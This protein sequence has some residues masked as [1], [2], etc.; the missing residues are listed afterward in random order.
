M[1]HSRV[2]NDVKGGRRSNVLSVDRGLAVARD[3]QELSDRFA[4]ETELNAASRIALSDLGIL[5]GQMYDDLT[6]QVDTASARQ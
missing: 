1:A 6:N 4:A 3:W 5:S 2:A